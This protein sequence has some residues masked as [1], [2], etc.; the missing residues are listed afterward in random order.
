MPLVDA[1]KFHVHLG[2]IGRITVAKPHDVIRST[3]KP[4]LP[5]ILQFPEFF[6]LNTRRDVVE[7]FTFK[8][9]VKDGLPCRRFWHEPTLFLHRGCLSTL[10]KDNA[11]YSPP[12][13]SSRT[14]GP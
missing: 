8:R 11:T 5:V 10:F 4:R 6:V 3:L 2:S 14:P 13:T 12:H 9:E 7:P 1:Q